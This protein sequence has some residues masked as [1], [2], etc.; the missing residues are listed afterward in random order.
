[1][2]GEDYCVAMDLVFYVYV[3]YSPKFCPH[4]PATPSIQFS[5]IS[6]FFVF[7]TLLGISSSL[8]LCRM[9]AQ[10]FSTGAESFFAIF[11]L[12]YLNILPVRVAVP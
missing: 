1:M 8:D 9:F 10:H 7:P 3:H 4:K 12:F 2:L 11:F 5:L 6:H